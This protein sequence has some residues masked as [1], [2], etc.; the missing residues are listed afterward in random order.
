MAGERWQDSLVGYCGPP[1][2]LQPH[3]GAGGRGHAR[4]GLTSI[5]PVHAGGGG[6]SGPV[7]GGGG[8]ACH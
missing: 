3:Q 2:D 4:G 6:V 7:D 5:S 8:G 1:T